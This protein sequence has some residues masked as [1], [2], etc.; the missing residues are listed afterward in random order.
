MVRVHTVGVSTVS[1]GSF[2]PL[3]QATPCSPFGCGLSHQTGTPKTFL[4]GDCLDLLELSLGTLPASRGILLLGGSVGHQP[5]RDTDPQGL[6]L[7]LEV[8]LCV[9]S[10]TWC[11][12]HIWKPTSVN[13]PLVFCALFILRLSLEGSACSTQ[14]LPPTLGRLDKAM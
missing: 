13:S 10:S 12:L 14:A 6:V 2:F 5:P 9:L 7:P 1:P 11:T 8:H 4:T 3:P